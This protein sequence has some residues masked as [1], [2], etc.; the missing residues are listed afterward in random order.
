MNGLFRKYLMQGGGFRKLAVKY[1][2]STLKEKRRF[3]QLEM[4]V[5]ADGKALR[6]YDASASFF[7]RQEGRVYLLGCLRDAA[8]A[9]W[10]HLSKGLITIFKE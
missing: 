4:Q 1:N 2:M 8:I 9:Q 6:D 10:M 3:F 5:F 7:I